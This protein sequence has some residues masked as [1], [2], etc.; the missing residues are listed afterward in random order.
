M[1]LASPCSVE[2]DT[3]SCSLN[4]GQSVIAGQRSMVTCRA[5]EPGSVWKVG[6]E[7]HRPGLVTGAEL[8]GSEPGWRMEECGA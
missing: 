4:T 6:L 2:D 7:G 1:G 8:A 5:P 3:S